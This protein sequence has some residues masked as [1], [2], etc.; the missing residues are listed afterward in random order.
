MADLVARGLELRGSRGSEDG[1]AYAT[2]LQQGLVCGVD[3]GVGGYARD[4]LLDDAKRH[5]GSPFL[6]RAVVC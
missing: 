6:G 3:D 5:G 4:V 2:A 1:T